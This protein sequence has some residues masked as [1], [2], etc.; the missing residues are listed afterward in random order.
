MRA[1]KPLGGDIM[2][3]KIGLIALLF[4][5]LLAIPMVAFAESGD[6]NSISDD[7]TNEVKIMSDPLG[8]HVRLLQ[9][10]KSLTKNVLTGQIVLDVINKNHP[11]A[12]TTTAGVTLDSLEALADELK[13]IIEN[14]D[15]NMSV[16]KFVEMKKEGI[17]L[18]Q[19]FKEQTRAFLTATDKQEIKERVQSIDKNELKSISEQTE[20]IRN[21]FNA[22]KIEAL[23]RLLGVNNPELIQKIRDGNITKQEVEDAVTAAYNELS[24]GQQAAVDSLLKENAIKK[25]VA[26]K[27]IVKKSEEKLM[28][29]LLEREKERL[30]KL[31]E[32]YKKRAEDANES[33]HKEREQRMENLSEKI[34][35]I[36]HNLEKK[37]RDHQ[38]E[39]DD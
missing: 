11:D 34:D 28:E 22:D 27:E 23:L 9:L 31:G 37:L 1:G 35:E 26:E 39:S 2:K 13:T 17:T 7:T 19:D 18:T 6:T 14:A 38:E 36:S 21:Q 12:N 3:N 30:E 5:A 29:R 15:T 24:Q 10:E 25:I 4:V 33:G 20:R 8:A 16:Q 32:W